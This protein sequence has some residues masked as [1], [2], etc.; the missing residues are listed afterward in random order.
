VQRELWGRAKFASKLPSVEDAP[1]PFRSA[2]VAVLKPS[3]VVRSLIFGPAEDLIRKILPAS[4]LAILEDE[5][6]IV[7]GG[8]NAEP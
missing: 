8:E 2:M 4:L 7:V 3:D 5:W 6:I 1:E